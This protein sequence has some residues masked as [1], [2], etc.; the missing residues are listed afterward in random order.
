MSDEIDAAIG[1]VYEDLEGDEDVM[2]YDERHGVQSLGILTIDDP[3]KAATVADYLRKRIAGKIVVE[4]GAGV[5]FLAVAMGRHASKV[6]AIEAD[7]AWSWM[8]TRYL[9]R[10]KP[11][12]VSWLFG[13]AEQFDGMIQADVAVFCTRS[14]KL[15]MAR[16]AE[17]FAPEVI[18]VWG[19]LGDKEV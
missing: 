4:I 9:Y 3:E 10:E 15:S 16:A 6:Y 5:G 7:P 14:G 8:F 18:D 11:E 12:N 2:A 1:Q 17:M 19:F 13:S